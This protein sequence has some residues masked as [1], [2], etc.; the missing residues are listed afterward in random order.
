M[1]RRIVALTLAVVAAFG[2]TA[3]T[4]SPAPSSNAPSSNASAPAA[5]GG[6]EGSSGEQAG[7][8]QSTAEACALVQDSIS[9]A[10]EQFEQV[11]SQDPAVVVEAMKTAVQNLGEAASQVTNEEVGALIPQLQDMFGQVSQIME[12]LVAG[13]TARLAELGELGTDFQETTQKLQELCAPE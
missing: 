12:A 5:G 9:S 6:S 4:G 1:S 2:L 8:G 10:T 13:D 3:C 7:G 11:A